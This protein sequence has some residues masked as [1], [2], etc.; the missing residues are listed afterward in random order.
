MSPASTPNCLSILLWLGHST[1]VH[2]GALGTLTLRVFGSEL[3]PRAQGDPMPVFHLRRCRLVPT[4]WAT[5]PTRCADRVPPGLVESLEANVK[6]FS[7][8]S[9]REARHGLSIWNNFHAQF[10]SCP[11]NRPSSACDGQK[12][13]CVVCLVPAARSNFRYQQDEL[14]IFLWASALQFALD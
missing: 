5:D 1:S 8:V 4:N 3:P 10:P 9:L 7:L 14:H 11:E 2:F 13:T 12:N 6:W